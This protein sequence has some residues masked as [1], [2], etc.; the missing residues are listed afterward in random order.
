MIAESEIQQRV[1]ALVKTIVKEEALANAVV[2]DALLADIGLTSMD[3]VNLMLNVEAEFDF[4]IPQG[5]ITP[6]NFASV[7]AIQKM[8]AKNIVPARAA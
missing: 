1:M 2:P 3:M 5:D 4:S 6:Q 8:V 7:V